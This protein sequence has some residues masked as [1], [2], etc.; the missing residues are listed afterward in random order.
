MKTKEDFSNRD[1][2]VELGVVIA[3]LRKKAGMSQEALAEKANISRSTLSAI[4]AANTIRPFSLDILFRIADALDVR[5]GD[6]L[7]SSLPANKSE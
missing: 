6:L 1:R 7:N 4:E 3:A 5:A 2:F